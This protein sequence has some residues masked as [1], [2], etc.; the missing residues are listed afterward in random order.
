[1]GRRSILVLAGAAVLLLTLVAPAFAARGDDPYATPVPYGWLLQ[2]RS[3][4]H[5]RDVTMRGFHNFAKKV[6]VTIVDPGKDAVS[7]ADD[8]TASGIPLYRL[9]GRIDDGNPG[10]FNT[11]LATTAPGY[12]VEVA[13]VDGYTATFT[14]AEVAALGAKL[15]VCDRISGATSL[16]LGSASIKNGVASWKP[17]WPLKVFSSD[18]GI[19]G[20]R[21]VGAVERISIVPVTVEA[22]AA[23]PF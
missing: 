21:K 19:F 18:A 12:T 22:A 13:G 11:K 17:L 9:V 10:T 23:A 6:G 4:T 15:V 16:G 14:S 3:A 20:S 7:T 8:T 5:N 2:L 1:M